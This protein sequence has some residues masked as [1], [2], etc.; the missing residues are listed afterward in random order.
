MSPPSTTT[1][2]STPATLG[3]TLSM[4]HTPTLSTSSSAASTRPTT[5]PELP[6]PSSTAGTLTAPPAGATPPTLLMLTGSLTLV[7]FMET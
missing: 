4:D 1:P 7:M 6:A 5:A 2:N 3:T